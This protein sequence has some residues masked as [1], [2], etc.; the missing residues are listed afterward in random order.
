[1]VVHCDCVR[2]LLPGVAKRFVMN[3]SNYILP[4]IIIGV[5]LSGCAADVRAADGQPESALENR[6][7]SAVNASQPALLRKKV[8]LTQFDVENPLQIEDIRNIYD[9][10][11]KFFAR[12]LAQSGDFISIYSPMTI[13]EQAT[14]QQTHEVIRL[15]HQYGAQ[16]VISGRVMSAA[17]EQHEGHWGTPFGAYQTRHFDMELS[18][19]HI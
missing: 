8:L 2:C 11:P 1:M 10:L 7:A 17:V 19:I 15:A 18:L 6:V 4:A 13:P 14:D 12:K 16:F 5:L 3:V 9:N